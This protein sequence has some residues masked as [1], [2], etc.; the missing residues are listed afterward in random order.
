MGRGGQP[1]SFISP[2]PVVLVLFPK[3]NVGHYRSIALPTSKR[4]DIDSLEGPRFFFCIKLD[5]N[6]DGSRLVAIFRI[7]SLTCCDAIGGRN[8]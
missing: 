7:E 2:T 5:F 6:Y 1:S 3:K 4:D 8:G